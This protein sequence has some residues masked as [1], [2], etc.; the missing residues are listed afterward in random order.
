MSSL[1][2]VS[3]VTSVFFVILLLQSDQLCIRSLKTAAAK[4]E[5][6]CVVNKRGSNANRR[7]DFTHK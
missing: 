4:Q 3:P 1:I 2:D 7:A 6:H 5:N